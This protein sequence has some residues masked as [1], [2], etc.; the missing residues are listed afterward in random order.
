M[1]TKHIPERA[2][3]SWIIRTECT[4]CK[5]GTTPDEIHYAGGIFKTYSAAIR[6]IESRTAA[7]MLYG[8]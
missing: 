3:G 8:I 7:E 4:N 2:G 6:E 5:G 1:K